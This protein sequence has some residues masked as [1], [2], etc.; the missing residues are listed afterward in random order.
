MTTTF[1][2]LAITIALYFALVDHGHWR[3]FNLINRCVAASI[4][5]QPNQ[6]IAALSAGAQNL[7]DDEPWAEQYMPIIMANAQ[8]I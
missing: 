7:A 4:R 3:E 8:D 2:I 1:I 6:V 5:N